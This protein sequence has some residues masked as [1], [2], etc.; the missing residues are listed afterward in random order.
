M[1]KT[2][3][4]RFGFSRQPYAG[5]YAVIE[6]VAT[7]VRKLKPKSGSEGTEVWLRNLVETLGGTISVSPTLEWENPASGS[8]TIRRDDAFEITLSPLTPPLRDNFTIA[9]ELGHFVLHYLLSEGTKEPIQ[10]NRYGTDKLEIQAN[11]FA[12]ALLMPCDEFLGQATTLDDD[13]FRLAAH[14]GVSEPAAKVRL[15]CLKREQ[16]AK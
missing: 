13:T 10:F 1:W 7:S 4:E 5:S 2:L 15:E 16:S 12:A 14:F 6:A 8:L 11:R 3:S 9:H